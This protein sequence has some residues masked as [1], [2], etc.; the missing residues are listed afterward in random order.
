[1]SSELLTKVSE[2]VEA[3]G[4]VEALL[5]LPVAALDLAVV[6]GRVGSD[7]LVAYAQGSGGGLKERPGFAR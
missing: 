3:V 6:P 7:Q 2:G 1:V 5:V 4:A